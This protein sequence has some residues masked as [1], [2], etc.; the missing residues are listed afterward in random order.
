MRRDQSEAL[1]VIGNFPVRTVR[2]T[3]QRTPK[4]EGEGCVEGRLKEGGRTDACEMLKK[5]LLLLLI[6][7]KK[8]KII[9]EKTIKIIK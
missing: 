6:L 4:Y 3:S 2:T 9:N 8:S 7:R 5:S 1:G